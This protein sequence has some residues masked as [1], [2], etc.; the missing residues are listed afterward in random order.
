MNNLATLTKAESHTATHPW[1]VETAVGRISAA[2]PEAA[3]MLGVLFNQAE[4]HSDQAETLKIDAEAPVVGIRLQ[5]K[6]ACYFHKIDPSSYDQGDLERIRRQI[7]FTTNFPEEL[8][9]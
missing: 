9:S 1:H 7:R 5:L 2:N 3:I 6:S 8:A 4:V